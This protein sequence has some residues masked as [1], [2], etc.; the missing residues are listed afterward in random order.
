MDRKDLLDQLQNLIKLDIDAIHAYDQAIKHIDQPIIKENL[1]RFQADHRRHVDHLSAKVRELGE[2][3]PAFAPD[4][5]GFFIE[6]FTALRSLT[7]TKGALEAMETNERLTNSRYEKAS[8][9]DAPSDISILVQEY[10]ADEKRHLA[11]I[12]EAL[13]SGEFK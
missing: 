5:K 1:V 7:G 12:R 2:T 6:G 4:F 8:A 9:M 3:P 11:F 10:W 13:N